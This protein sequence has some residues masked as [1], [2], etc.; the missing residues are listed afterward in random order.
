MRFTS[1][2]STNGAEK[3]PNKF[4][5][6]DCPTNDGNRSASLAPS[7]DVL[8]DIHSMPKA[9]KRRIILSDDEDER[10]S[11]TPKVSKSAGTPSSVEWIESRKVANLTQHERERNIQTAVEQ[12][13][14]AGHPVKGVKPIVKASK[15]GYSEVDE[16]DDIL[17]HH[18]PIASAAA[19][20]RALNSQSSAGGFRSSLLNET[21]NDS[22]E[23]ALEAARALRDQAKLE[24]RAQRVE[25]LNHSRHFSAS[26]PQN[27]HS[28]GTSGSSKE[29]SIQDIIANGKSSLD[30]IDLDSGSE[31]EVVKPQRRKARQ[32]VVEVE[33][34][35]NGA[36]G[37]GEDDYHD[38]DLDRKE[39]QALA[40]K[41]LR[42][43]ESL[44]AN[45]RRS[46]IQ[47]ET[48]ADDADCFE[49]LASPSHSGANALATRDCI[50]LTTIRRA[51]VNASAK[52][53]SSSSSAMDMQIL[54]DED[55]SKLCPELSLKG[56]QLVGVNWLKLL[57]QNN[58]NGVLADD[59]GLGTFDVLIE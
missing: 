56:Y 38:G 35:D 27:A 9:T 49:T 53:S 13:K 48:G 34:S 58:V 14:Q 3:A 41:V 42:Q 26:L 52:Q 22:R 16:S 32:E 23:E 10:P 18:T 8:R 29:P 1:T 54:Y 6:F 47:W 2:T 5:S 15:V 11:S 46:L 7:V 31:E 19:L 28:S 51:N 37:S 44:S 50:D 57:H 30:V 33:D 59:M 12:R 20:K 24:N 40:N 55:I 36:S 43:C 45:L 17:A 25:Q 4:G 39:L 21:F